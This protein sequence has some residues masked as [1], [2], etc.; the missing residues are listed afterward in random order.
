[1]LYYHWSSFLRCTLSSCSSHSGQAVCH[2]LAHVSSFHISRNF[3][4]SHR[5][6]ISHWAA[7]NWFKKGKRADGQAALQGWRGFFLTPDRHYTSP[8]LTLKKL[9]CRDER[10]QNQNLVAKEMWCLNVRKSLCLLPHLRGYNVSH[11]LVVTFFPPV[12]PNNNILL[13]RLN[14]IGASNRFK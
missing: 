14:M 5:S 4:L 1:M 12:Q 7:L 11:A 2:Q 3:C 9:K 13:L 10:R 8:V 6:E